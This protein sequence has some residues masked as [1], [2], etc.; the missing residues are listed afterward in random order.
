MGFGFGGAG[1][2]REA[3]D[4]ASFALANGQDREDTVTTAHAVHPDVAAPA[5]LSSGSAEANQNRYTGSYSYE[6]RPD[7]RCEICHF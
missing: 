6:N 1:A 2:E 5:F 4:A 3:P 7:N